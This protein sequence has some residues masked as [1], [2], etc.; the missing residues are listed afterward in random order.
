V[1]TTIP[2]KPIR[3]HLVELSNGAKASK[4]IEFL[5]PDSADVSITGGTFDPASMYSEQTMTATLKVGDKPLGPCANVCFKE[6]WTVEVAD[7]FTGKERFTGFEGRLDWIP[8]VCRT[9]VHGDPRDPNKITGK[10]QSPT[11]TDINWFYY[12][13]DLYIAIQQIPVGTVVLRQTHEYQFYENRC[14]GGGW[15]P[16][17]VKLKK[18]AKVKEVTSTDGQQ[19][20]VLAWEITSQRVV[21][22]D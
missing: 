1:A 19:V 7:E 18:E 2:R 17:L 20:K 21:N 11:L 12:S 15:G 13:V 14:S 9:E 22:G 16:L 6:R 4:V 3:S 10:W 8:S 5:P